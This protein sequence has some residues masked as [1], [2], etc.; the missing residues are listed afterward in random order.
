M[1]KNTSISLGPRYEKFIETSLAT[2]RYQNTSEIMRAALRLLEE[3]E[4]R[5][6]MLSN[7]ISEGINSGIATDFNPQEHLAALKAAK[8]SNG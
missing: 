8:R 2:G 3:E 5:F 6:S 4:R 1:G 7:A